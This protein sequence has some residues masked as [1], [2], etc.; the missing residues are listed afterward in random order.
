MNLSKYNNNYS[1]NVKSYYKK[2]IDKDFSMWPHSHEYIEIM[3]IL[4]G[5]CILEIYDNKKIVKSIEV[6]PNT[7]IIIV[8][9]FYHSIRCNEETII[10]NLEFASNF[11]S[12]IPMV[13]TMQFL[14]TSSEWRSIINS[15]YGIV[16]FSDINGIALSIDKIIQRLQNTG[17]S[18]DDIYT[19]SSVFHLFVKLAEC[20]N[21]AYQSNDSGTVYFSRAASI[22]KREISRNVSVKEIANELNVTVSYLERI[23]KEC[24]HQSV[25]NYAD[26]LKLELIKNE[27]LETDNDINQIRIK[28]GYD[29]LAKL[30]YQFKQRYHMIPREYRKNHMKNEFAEGREEYFDKT[31]DPNE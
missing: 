19:D 9:S 13:Q 23:F 3:E 14:K 28:Y 22:I 10:C 29:S 8:S 15:K 6:K 4:S 1:L 21:K 11:N 27:L 7:I 30:N 24:I 26:S 25:K 12:Q 16:T 2:S 20:Y 31:F 17:L 18:K 5:C